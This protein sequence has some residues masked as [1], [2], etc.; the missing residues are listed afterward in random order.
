MPG[1]NPPAGFQAHCQS[2][3]PKRIHEPTA[4]AAAPLDARVDRE[5]LDTHPNASSSLLQHRYIAQHEGLSDGGPSLGNV[6]TAAFYAD[7]IGSVSRSSNTNPA[8]CFA[9]R[10]A[11]GALAL[12]THGVDLQS[13][14]ESISNAFQE[15]PF[16]G[17]GCLGIHWPS[18][19]QQDRDAEEA[20]PCIGLVPNQNRAI[21]VGT[22]VK[23][24]D[25]KI[26]TNLNGKVC[27]VLSF[28]DKT[29]RFQVRIFSLK[30]RPMGA[31]P[32]SGSASS[33]QV[34]VKLIKGDN[35]KV[36]SRTS[37]SSPTLQSTFL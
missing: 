5:V 36:L 22:M 29:G 6:V 13:V 33:S 10:L 7:D 20:R 11:T 17:C 24:V 8:S 2:T 21:Q 9:Q 16:Q 19:P 32:C 15:S 37:C 28:D 14:S 25:L 3:Q 31:N 30:A 34:G 4:T 12:A 26:A 23:I 35:L 27:E 18:A 1:M